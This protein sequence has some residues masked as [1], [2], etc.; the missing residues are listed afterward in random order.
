MK[1]RLRNRLLNIFS[2]L[3][4]SRHFL[5]N[6]SKQKAASREQAVQ[7]EA[8]VQVDESERPEVTAEEAF[9]QQAMKQLEHVQA[10]GALAVRVDSKDA[11]ENKEEREEPFTAA[12]TIAGVI[13]RL[14]RNKNGFWGQWQKDV[15]GCFFKKVDEAGCMKISRQLQHQLRE[16]KKTTVSVGAAVFPFVEFKKKEILA[17]AGK[18]LA[19]AAF[20]GPDSVVMFDAVSLNISGDRLYQEG[21]IDGAVRE[22]RTALKLDAENVNVLNSLGVC[23]GVQGAYKKAL[24]SFE[25]VI[26]LDPDHM[27][28]Y[29]NAGYVCTLMDRNETALEYFLKAYDTG[30]AAFEVL[31][32]I[33]KLYLKTGKP[34]QGKLFLEKALAVNPDAATACFQLGEC[35]KALGDQERAKLQYEAAVK[36]NPQDAA[37]LSALGALYDAEGENPEISTLFCEKS[38]EI[39]PENGLFQ[40]RLGRVYANNNMLDKAVDAFENAV[41][42]GHDGTRALAGAKERLARAFREGLSN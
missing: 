22:F 14:C 42:L 21:D 31:F 2:G 26:S 40:Y 36:K 27:M 20:L 24:R 35:F 4:T 18:A 32:Q 15:F 39:S 9:V 38:V 11:G 19:H 5:V 34:E 23:Y 3:D 17:N 6:R 10:F 28:A 16:R 8:P 29:Y 37:A 13:N 7:T 33:G 25:S 1:N 30:E 12:D 41:R